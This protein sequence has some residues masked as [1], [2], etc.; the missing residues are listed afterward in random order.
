MILAVL[1]KIRQWQLHRF[2]LVLFICS[3]WLYSPY[4]LCTNDNTFTI[5]FLSQSDRTQL[6]ALLAEHKDDMTI[7]P[8]AEQTVSENLINIGSWL[9]IKGYTTLGQ[10]VLNQALRYAESYSDA[11]LGYIYNLLANTAESNLPQAINW[12]EKAIELGNLSA[13]VNLGVFYEKQQQYDNAA[14]IYN[15]CTMAVDQVD[16]VDKETVALA[17][18]NLGSLYYN[19][20]L[21]KDNKHDQ[22]V[23]GKLWQ[24][25]YEL[26]PY[27]L[28][29]HYNL[30][31]YNRYVLKN[32][33]QARYH[34][35][36]CAWSY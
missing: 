18:L 20:V 1:F 28:D 9:L 27:D 8:F 30:A 7:V 5:E 32:F 6:Q 34:L 26:N 31:I 35:T 21:N 23:A 3:L 24:A 11:E 2:S 12:Y 14:N 13:C 25:S 16:I 33:T 36:V 10:K 4:T 19:G 29:I 15:K 22:Q 17:Y